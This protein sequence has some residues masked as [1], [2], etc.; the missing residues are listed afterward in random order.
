MDRRSFLCHQRHR[1]AAAARRSARR[2]A[3]VTG[4]GGS[5]DARAQ[6]RCSRRSSRSGFAPRPT[7]PPR[8]ASTRAPTPR[9]SRSSTP[10]PHRPRG[11]EDLARNRARDRRGSNAISPATL[12]RRGQAQPRSRALSTRDQRPSRRRVG[13]SIRAQRPYPITQQGGAYFSM[14]DFL[15]TAHTIDNARRR[16]GLSVAP[17]P[18]R[19]AC[20]TMTPPSSARRPRAA[21]SRRPGRSTS[22]SA[23]C[24]S[25]ATPPAEQST[26][27]ESIVRRARR[28]RASPATGRPRAATIVAEQR[29]SGAR[30]AD[31][32][33]ASS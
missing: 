17:A 7:S 5:G 25:C 22:R 31:R 12:S 15:N 32:G 11:A 14:P 23:R 2:F 9:S 24:A 27:V 8:S 26:M 18:V 19:D 30:P 4:S 6:R 33:D 20:S 13:T 16:R 21:S 28:P 10:G 1:R 3:A 29:L